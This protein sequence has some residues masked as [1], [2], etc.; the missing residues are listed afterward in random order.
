MNDT[1]HDD[2]G[3]L[4]AV[5]RAAS[6]L[7]DDEARRAPPEFVAGFRIVRRIGEGG[8]GVVYEAEQEQPRRRV[9]LKLLRCA[10]SS[11]S[12][13]RFEREGKALARLQH[14][15]IAAVHAAGTCATP[16]GEQPF[17]AMEFVDGE[18]ID[19]WLD[20]RGASHDLRLRLFADVCDAVHHAHQKGVIH[21]DLKP[22]NVFVDQDGRAR[23]LDF[24]VARLLD[25]E[26]DGAERQTIAGQL[27]GT[28]A[29]MS[30]E[31]VAADPS[32]V[33]VRSD[34]WSLGV[35][36]YQLLS[37]RL[38]IDVDGRTTAD[39]LRAI[40]E[41]EPRR[42]GTIAPD[43][44]GDVETIVHQ[45]LARDPAR[46]YP[47]ADALARDMRHFLAHEPIAA[48]PPSRAY[49]WSRFVRR[50]R[51]LVV[52]GAVAVLALIGGTIVAVVQMVEAQAQTAHAKGVNAW[53]DTLL[54][55]AD[56]NENGRVDI[57]LREAIER[58]ADRI[59]KLV[60]T[61]EVEASVRLMV[62][63]AFRSYGDLDRARDHLEKCLRL[64]RERFASP[65]DELAEA[66][67]ALALLYERVGRQRDSV[68]LYEDAGRQYL[69]LHGRLDQ[70]HARALVNAGGAL[71][72]LGDLD[73][74]EA[75]IRAG[76]DLLRESN[77]DHAWLGT[78][79]AHLANVERRRGRFDE[80]ERC[81]RETLAIYART[82][83]ADHPYA[84]IVRRNLGG[85]LAES[86]RFA[87]AE[88][89]FR[90]ALRI[91]RARHG[92]QHEW[93]LQAWRDLVAILRSQGR[94]DDARA[95]EA[96][97]TAARAGK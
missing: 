6:R 85:L 94:E 95:T 34:V 53:F 45:A 22:S 29:Y 55:F 30:P 32:A 86:K 37:G 54:T 35:I 84:A 81:M 13:R 1:G 49:L 68:S 20:R 43:C 96:D 12:L 76:V 17:L 21:R 63:H 69:E 18:P 51:A 10:S 42:L 7:R 73:G 92:E 70:R 36:L 52:A 44:R 38:P 64:R 31:Q 74:A 89:E 33:D 78:F 11:A 65:S 59:D 80:A 40:A 19:R 25:D 23:V 82:D 56:P 57:T 24:G 58:A 2:G 93:T 8:M 88:V 77:P 79:L 26:D 60:T 46:R 71:V 9:A 90:E 48:R 15:G 4:D 61:P 66:C 97:A 16:A 87:D 91:M 39:V 14:P 28:P 62:G 47:S 41:Q 83:Y 5:K 72:Q 27:V 3:F 50:N 75:R 67:N